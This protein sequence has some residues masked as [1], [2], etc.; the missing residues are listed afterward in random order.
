MSVQEKAKDIKICKSCQHY[1][2]EHFIY[3]GGWSLDLITYKG[4]YFNL[5]VIAF[6][7]TKESSMNFI[8]WAKLGDIGDVG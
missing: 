5:V 3:M 6:K 1:G 4:T 2:Q 7:Y 8:V